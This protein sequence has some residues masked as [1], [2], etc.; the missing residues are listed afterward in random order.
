LV[1]C[2][3]EDDDANDDYSKDCEG[4]V[5]HFDFYA[6]GNDDMIKLKCLKKKQV[7]SIYWWKVK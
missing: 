4:K 2:I 7:Q 6:D 5:K 1:H 3:D